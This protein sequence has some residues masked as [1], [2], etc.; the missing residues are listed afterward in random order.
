MAKTF[1]VRIPQHKSIKKIGLPILSNQSASL[2]VYQAQVQGFL[3]AL[4]RCRYM[5]VETKDNAGR[6]AHYFRY[7]YRM[8]R[9]GSQSLLIQYKDFRKS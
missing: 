2:L 1:R 4:E 6:D 8:C 5:F 3:K 7:V 9:W